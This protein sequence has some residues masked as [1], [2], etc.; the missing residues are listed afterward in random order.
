M[1]DGWKGVFPFNYV[2]CSFES[3]GKV[4]P[5]DGM[6]VADITFGIK[7]TEAMEKAGAK[8]FSFMKVWSIIAERL[9]ER[10]RG[11]QVLILDLDQG[12]RL[13]RRDL[14]LGGDGRK[15]LADESDPINGQQ[16][17]IFDRVPVVGIDVPHFLSGKYG[18]NSG[19]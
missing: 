4:A 19:Q 5:A 13:L 2:I 10:G 1:V 8:R 18:Y 16:G 14:I 17:S 3:L 12:L 6:L 7:L 9:I 11:R 15:R